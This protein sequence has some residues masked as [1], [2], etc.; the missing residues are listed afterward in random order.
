MV[1]HTTQR[2]NFAYTFFI[3]PSNP[4]HGA[5]HFFYLFTSTFRIE[6][7][8]WI[9]RRFPQIFLFSSS[10]PLFYRSFSSRKKR[11]R[12]LSS[13]WYTDCYCT[14]QHLMHFPLFTSLHSPQKTSLEASARL[15]KARRKLRLCNPNFETH[16]RRKTMLSRIIHGTLKDDSDGWQIYRYL[17]CRAHIILARTEFIT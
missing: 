8:K 1:Q 12:Q 2:H 15:K 9:M 13:E 10:S 4:V 14:A 3:P 11:D 6:I 16:A 17:F 7:I 5:F